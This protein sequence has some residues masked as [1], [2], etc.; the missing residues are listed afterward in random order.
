MPAFEDKWLVETLRQVDLSA[1]LRSILHIN[2]LLMSHGLENSHHSLN[3]ALET[4]LELLGNIR[5]VRKL[6]VKSV[7][8]YVDV[9]LSG[10]MYL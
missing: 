6:C 5:V 3:I 9:C 2:N 4:L 10:C 1:L 7:Y 8:R